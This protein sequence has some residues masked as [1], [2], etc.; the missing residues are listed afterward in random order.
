MTFRHVR[1]APCWAGALAVILTA[2]AAES[3]RIDFRADSNLVLIPVSVTDARDRLITG[4]SRGQFRV[5]EGKSE[6]RVLH[7]AREDAP[8]SVGIVFDSSGS[9]AGKLRKAQEAVAEFL[10]GASPG[11][12]FFLVTF[13][14]TAQL[15]VPFTDDVREIEH[16]SLV[17]QSAGKT[18]LL[19]AVSLAL[20]EMKHAR[21][22]RRALLL[23]SDGGDNHSRSTAG[24]LHEILREAGVWL[25]AIGIYDR[26]SPMLPEEDDGGAKLLA[27]MAEETG[28]RHLAIQNVSDLPQAAAQIGRELRS[29]YVIAFSPEGGAR[30][31]KYHRVQVKLVQQ[32]KLHVAARPGYWA[33]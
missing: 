16:R 33:R 29:Q 27:A 12:E 28:G 17:A 22:A 31:G 4:L 7:L 15:A 14:N 11:D 18:A 8:L 3:P 2:S 26:G 19:D 9:M 20:G 6:Q 25:Y 5:F 21:N 10:K 24:E 13:H 32:G 30:D 1:R 23:I